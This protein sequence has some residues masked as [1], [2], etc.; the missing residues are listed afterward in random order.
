VVVVDAE[1]VERVER[2]LV[3]VVVPLRARLSPRPN[4]SLNL[5]RVVVDAVVVLVARLT[6]DVTVVAVK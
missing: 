4:P 2:A 1:L 6:A 3:V 5:S